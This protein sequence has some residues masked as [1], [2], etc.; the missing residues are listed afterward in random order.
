MFTGKLSTLQG[1]TCPGRFS[2][3][4][5]F[6][7]RRTA[8]LSQHSPS[9]QQISGPKYLAS[10][11]SS[12]SIHFPKRRIKTIPQ[13]RIQSIGRTMNPPSRRTKTLP[14][15][16]NSP[17]LMW[18]LAWCSYGPTHFPS[19]FIRTWRRI[20]LQRLSFLHTIVLFCRHLITTG[21]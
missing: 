11:G 2:K 13:L 18:R 16:W 20:T 17:G 21:I 12:K 8:L 1:I 9:Y 6:D 14:G 19:S 10:I 5:D 4:R 7:F 3:S 15:S